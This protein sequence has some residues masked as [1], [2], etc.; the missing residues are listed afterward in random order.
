MLKCGFFLFEVVTKKRTK[1][2]QED[3]CSNLGKSLRNLN[4]KAMFGCMD[5]LEKARS[6]EETWPKLKF[7]VCLLE[8]K[9][10]NG[11]ELPTHSRVNSLPPT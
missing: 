2:S 6:S 11:L 5:L 9:L 1:D 10:E 4:F 7:G 8:T 3:L